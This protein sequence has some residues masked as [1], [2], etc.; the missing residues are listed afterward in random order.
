M[1]DRKATPSRRRYNRRRANARPSAARRR[2]IRAALVETQ[3]MTCPCCGIEMVEPKSSAIPG[4]RDIRDACIDHIVPLSH[5]GKYTLSN[6][7]LVCRAC[8][9]EHGLEINGVTRHYKGNDDER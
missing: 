3:G 1:S 4:A 8:N 2:K 9:E 6:L 7:R 5:G